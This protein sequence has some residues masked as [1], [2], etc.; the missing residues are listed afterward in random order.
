MLSTNSYHMLS[1]SVYLL[2]HMC[3]PASKETTDEKAQARVHTYMIGNYL[4]SN[5]TS[6]AP[7]IPAP[8]TQTSYGSWL[9]AAALALAPVLAAAA[10]VPLLP[11]ER[12]KR[13]GSSWLTKQRCTGACSHN[14]GLLAGTANVV[15]ADMQTTTPTRQDMARHGK[16]VYPP[17]LPAP[18]GRDMRFGDGLRPFLQNNDIQL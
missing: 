6:A 16:L 1:T 3:M 8:T 10:A 17:P 9:P 5:A 2:P 14:K 4:R 12:C 11:Y 7:T 13:L 18:C 15:V